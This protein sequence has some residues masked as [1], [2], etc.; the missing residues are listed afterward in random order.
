MFLNSNCRRLSYLFIEEGL[1]PSL[2]IDYYVLLLKP[3]L[4]VRY[5]YI[6]RLTEIA[7]LLKSFVESR[8]IYA[9]LCMY[10]LEIGIARLQ[11]L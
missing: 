5:Y 9:C 1:I 6:E 8:P 3:S 7:D 11:I 10:F 2:F 4:E